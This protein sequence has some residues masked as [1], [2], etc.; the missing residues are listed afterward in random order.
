MTEA[1]ALAEVQAG[2]VGPESIPVKLR[3]G[4]GL[5]TGL[6]ARVREAL[7]VLAE[8]YAGRATVPKSL[9][10]AFVDISG[11]MLPNRDVYSEEEQERIEDASIGL[12]EI[13]WELFGAGHS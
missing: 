3:E 9:A 8:S 6:L 13:G 2:L 12:V 11:S 7:T 1:E 4:L 5:D 10:L